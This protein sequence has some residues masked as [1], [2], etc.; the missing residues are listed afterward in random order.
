MVS[1]ILIKHYFGGVLAPCYHVQVASNSDVSFAILMAIMLMTLLDWTWN[2]MRDVVYTIS[3]AAANVLLD[4]S[5]H[6]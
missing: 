2:P 3:V 4:A 1:K 5:M 6:L